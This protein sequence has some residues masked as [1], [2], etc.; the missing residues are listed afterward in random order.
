MKK[1][2]ELL[3]GFMAVVDMETKTKY[4]EAIDDCRTYLCGRGMNEIANQLYECLYER[5]GVDCVVY[6]EGAAE[7]CYYLRTVMNNPELGW[8]VFEALGY[9]KPDFIE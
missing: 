4:Q 5:K 1:N 2:R 3:V 8:E 6:I 9:P 7:C